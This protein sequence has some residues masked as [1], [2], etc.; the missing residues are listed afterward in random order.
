MYTN[1]CDALCENG[2]LGYGDCLAAKSGFHNTFYR[3]QVSRI[4]TLN[5]NLTI[6]N[7]ITSLSEIDPVLANNVIKILDSQNN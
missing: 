6:D 1:L 4:L 7:L 3:D 5:S 2:A